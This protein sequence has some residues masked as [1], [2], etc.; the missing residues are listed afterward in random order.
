LTGWSPFD[1]L[2][3]LYTFALAAALAAVLRRWYD[4]VPWRVLAVF[5]LAV[6]ILFASSLFGGWILLPLGNLRGAAPFRNLPAPPP[7][8]YLQADLICEIAPW[9]LQVRR[10]VF[11][12]R[13]PLWNSHGGAGMPLLADPQS[14]AFQPLIALAWPLP[15]GSAA[16]VTSALRVLCALIFSF[17]FLRRQSLG[18]EAALCGALAYG[19]GGFLLFWLGWPIGN[20]AALLPGLL[21]AVVRCD[22]GEAGSP[23]RRDAVL[24]IL[25]TVAVLL[26]GHPETGLYELSCAG[27]LLL[28]RLRNRPDWRSRRASAT[29][30]GVAMAL[31][32]LVSAPLLLPAAAYLP[33]T[34][35][36]AVVAS[37]L[38]PKPLS[39]FAAA[40]GRPEVRAE[41]L[42]TALDRLLPIA[43]P[44]AFGDIREYWGG[45][46]LV[47]DGCGFVGAA[48]LLA[49]LLALWPGAVRRF[50][51]ERLAI[52]LLLASVLL[53]AQPPG[54]D[55]LVGRL[56]LFSATAVHRHHRLLL[57]AT[58]A[59]AWLAACTVER[60]TR[61]EVRRFHLVVTAAALAALTV[62][63]YLCHPSP[64]SGRVIT[65]VLE[66]GLAAQ[67]IAVAVASGFLLLIPGRR[68]WASWAL[69]LLIGAELIA[70]LRSVNS[71]TP[72]GFAFP[73]RPSIAFLQRH[74]G[75]YRMVAMGDTFF[76][77][78]PQVYGLRDVRIG[79]P[80]IP[81][82]YAHL[83][84]PLNR[85]PLTPRFRRPSLPLYDLLGVRY[86]MTRAGV[87]M[88]FRRAYADA[89]AWIWE[90]P[91]PLPLLFLPRRARL[92][93][94][95]PWLPWVQRNTDFATRSLVAATPKHRRLWR[96]QGKAPS[97]VVLLTLGS[98]RLRARAVLAEPR[99]LASSI[100]QDGN[101]HVLDRGDLVPTTVVNG[102]FVGAW[103]AAGEHE[104]QL[105]YRPPR[106]VAGCTLAALALAAAA[107]LWVPRPA[108]ARC[109]PE[110]DGQCSR[111]G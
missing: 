91:R 99:L 76:P 3:G 48:A 30:C 79:N 4:P 23:M 104:L 7:G 11:D 109:Y 36:A 61:G 67:L 65:G 37:Q 18:R 12:G 80:S 2:P 98:A 5:A 43:A 96:A 49:A 107:A 29:R 26:G 58:L 47:E 24:L 19:L 92:A 13:W 78:V 87:E 85:N 103:L 70:G 17:L 35:R 14:Q 62:G 33:Q 71:A 28:A 40:L 16:A 90:R 69:A 108:S 63:T 82:V 72:K 45:V 77:N 1:L 89:D 102:P 94:G 10:A 68:L 86:L 9:Q 56:P 111:S 84:F 101:W 59:L 31:A 81:A 42:D 44:R 64:Q 50:P 60:W 53:I 20:G 22:P 66:G 27:L 46:N 74:L 106:F 97:R 95:E 54:F 15:I 52:A 25:V 83:T 21:Y 75:P 88:R 41:W 73:P 6:S 8:N 105:I 34:Q 100:F 93:R 39:V 55:N 110:P 51:Q 57:V 32:V 38:A